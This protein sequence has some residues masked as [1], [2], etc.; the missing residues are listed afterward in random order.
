MNIEK[1]LKYIYEETMKATGVPQKYKSPELSFFEKEQCEQQRYW[2]A[3]WDRENK[4]VGEQWKPI[5]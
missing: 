4:K 2:R 3:L 5:R 1:C